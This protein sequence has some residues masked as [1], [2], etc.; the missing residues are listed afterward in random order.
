MRFTR[1]EACGA[2]ALMAA[3]Q[4]PKC[5][6]WLGLR[7]DKG[8][9]VPLMRCRSCQCYYP[10][11][12]GGCKWCG[13]P[14]ATRGFSFVWGAPAVVM[15]AGA[16]WGA[17]RVMD[18][19]AAERTLPRMAQVA[20]AT[21]IA[22]IPTAAEPSPATSAPYSLQDSSTPAQ[23]AAPGASP[24]GSRAQPA[25][26]PEPVAIRNAAPAPNAN[27]PAAPEP[28]VSTSPDA[29]RESPVIGSRIATVADAVAPGPARDD[30]T[31]PVTSADT[32]RPLPGDQGTARTWVNVRAATGRAA[33]VLGVLTPETRVHFGET[34]G[35]WIRVRTA[36][37]TGWADRRLFSV[38]R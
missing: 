37:V 8:E 6:H 3:S 15:L 5:S 20:P 35:A 22:A 23:P 18:R 14:P 12:Q 10:R 9:S 19:S 26:T 16:A 32:V 11:R 13:T 2:K 7:D 36:H 17:V 38:V 34:R 33:E 28:G 1:C 24:A 4:C 29:R 31:A 21:R 27:V 30:P 25:S